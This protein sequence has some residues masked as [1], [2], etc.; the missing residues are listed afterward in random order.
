MYAAVRTRSDALSLVPALKQALWSVAGGVPVSRVEPLDSVID[1]G[2]RPTRL[3]AVLAALAGGVTL[4]LG[5]LGIYAV[6][7]HA[8]AR[9][10]RELGVRSALGAGRWQLLRGELSGATRIVVT[11]LGAGLILAWLAGRALRGA[12][13]GIGAFDAP[14]LLA[15]LLLLAAVAYAAAFFPARRA[16]VVSPARVMRED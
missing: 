3:L 1:R 16:S 9:R 11:G 8:V 15:T 14:S 13:F 12:L 7:S 5:A 10:M 2:L 4:L 6:I